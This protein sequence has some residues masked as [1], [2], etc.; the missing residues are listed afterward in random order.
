[1]FSVPKGYDETL[2]GYVTNFYY[3]S[4]EGSDSNQV[5]ILAV[6]DDRLLIRLRGETMD[7]NYYDGSKPATVISA[8]T[9]FFHNAETMRSMD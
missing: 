1:M 8:E 3:C 4:H 2:G 5:E 9:W 7:V 6:E